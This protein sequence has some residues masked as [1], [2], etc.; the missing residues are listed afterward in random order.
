[1]SSSYSLNK[2][3]NST[4]AA[5]MAAKA[6]LDIFKAM[7]VGPLHE[8][9]ARARLLEQTTMAGKPIRKIKTAEDIYCKMYINVSTVCLVSSHKTL[10][11]N[12]SKSFLV[13]R[14]KYLAGCPLRMCFDYLGIETLEWLEAVPDLKRLLS[15]VTDNR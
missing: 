9:V 1:M 15:N 11:I 2:Q 4:R 5:R 8:D 6:S 10:T 14:E 13:A 3:T 12:K 7:P